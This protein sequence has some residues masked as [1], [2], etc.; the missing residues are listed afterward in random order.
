[1][2]IN[3]TEITNYNIKSLIGKNRYHIETILLINKKIKTTKI[4]KTIYLINIILV[5]LLPMDVSVVNNSLKVSQI[6]YT[7]YHIISTILISIISLLTIKL[8]K[9]NKKN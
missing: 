5:I 8:I 3:N 2:E 1:M 6:G 4:L 9:I 7:I